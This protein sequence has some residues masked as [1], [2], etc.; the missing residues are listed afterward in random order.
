MVV[1]YILTYEEV[2]VEIFERHVN[3]VN[4][5]VASAKVLWSSLSEEGGTWEAEADMM[6]KLGC[7]VVKYIY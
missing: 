4:K 3:L 2:H 7:I 5:E 6:A 1:K